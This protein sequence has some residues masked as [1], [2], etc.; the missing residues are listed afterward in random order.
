M[1][2]LTVSYEYLNYALR[3]F[4]ITDLCMVPISYTKLAPNK[5]IRYMADY[6]DVALD[7]YCYTMCT[8]S[9][10]VTIKEAVSKGYLYSEG[11]RMREMNPGSVVS[12]VISMFPDLE[13][14]LEQLDKKRNELLNSKDLYPFFKV[15]QV[16]MNV[17]RRMKKGGV[18]FFIRGN[19]KAFSKNAN[20]HL[21]KEQDKTRRMLFNTFVHLKKLWNNGEV[22]SLEYMND[23]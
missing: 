22:P 7:E 16:Q 15:D 19:L 9:C 12:F 11:N 3:E 1:T 14:D 20:G 23:A 21:D 17:Y 18:E 5:A 2:D 8:N 4:G 13:N 10:P 6:I